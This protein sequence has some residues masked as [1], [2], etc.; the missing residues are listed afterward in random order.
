MGEIICLMILVTFLPGLYLCLQIPLWDKLICNV[1]TRAI[2]ETILVFKTSNDCLQ[3]QLHIQYLS[4]KKDNV[5]LPGLA[6]S[7][8]LFLQDVA[9]EVDQ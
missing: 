7:L 6:N 1:T 3:Q 8:W 2:L 5:L 9:I 4:N